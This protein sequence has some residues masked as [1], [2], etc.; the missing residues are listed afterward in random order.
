MRWRR[1]SRPE[2]GREARPPPAPGG[3]PPP[4]ER[5]ARGLS[6]AALEGRRRVTVDFHAIPQLALVKL[7]ALTGAALAS[8]RAEPA[9]RAS[10][11]ASP[12][13]RS[14]RGA[15]SLACFQRS[16]RWKG[17][18]FSK[19]DRSKALA[20][21][22]SAASAA[23]APAPRSGRRGAGARGPSREGQRAKRESDT[24]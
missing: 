18:C 16:K 12:R 15:L 11:A 23:A 10:G 3:G 6:E 1:G 2:R 24:N 7:F 14:L 5:V 17:S 19:N 9:S 20:D 13:R 8:S 22:P 4:G 21:F